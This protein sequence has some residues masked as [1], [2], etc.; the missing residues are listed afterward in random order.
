VQITGLGTPIF[1]K[2]VDKLLQIHALVTSYMPD[3]SLEPYSLPF[4]EG[5]PC[6]DVSTRYF[7][8]RI[9]DP[10]GEIVPFSNYVD[11]RGDLQ[12]V[13][14][15][16][17]NLFHGVDNKV[18]YYRLV[19]DQDTERPRCAQFALMMWTIL[20]AMYSFATFD[21]AKFKIG[22]IVEIQLSVTVAAVKDGR[23]KMIPQL[24]SLAQLDSTH[25]QVRVQHNK[26]ILLLMIS[27]GSNSQTHE[28]HIISK[29]SNQNQHQTQSR[30]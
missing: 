21:P 7:T 3:G 8:S 17:D 27:T 29:P 26:S 12:S 24:R 16:N 15:T 2:C 10:M 25:R 19:Q 9:D 1:Q 4:L 14:M 30:L 11:P 23:F 20:T 6:L 22:D 5:H 18:L 13:M 28:V